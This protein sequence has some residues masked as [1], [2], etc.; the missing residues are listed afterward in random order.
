MIQGAEHDLQHGREV[1]FAGE[2]PVLLGEPEAVGDGGAAGFEVLLEQRGPDG[3]VVLGL[4]DQGSQV[5]AEVV[6]GEQRDHAGEEGAH[7]GQDVAGVGDGDLGRDALE[8]VEH[9]CALRWPPA[10]DGLLAHA[11]PGRDRLDGDRTT[12]TH[13]HMVVRVERTLPVPP[14]RAYRAWLE[15]GL[16]RRWM[17][18][19]RQEVTRVEIDERAGGAWRTWKAD[20]GVIVGGFD[21][22]LLELVPDRRLV[23]RWGFIGPQRR[24]G[25]S[26]DTLL[27]VSFDPGPA[28]GTVVRLVHERLGELAA[29]MPDIAAS[30]GPGWE[31]V[32]HLSASRVYSPVR[33]SSNTHKGSAQATS[34]LLARPS[35]KPRSP[36]LRCKAR[37][38]LKARCLARL[39]GPFASQ[40]RRR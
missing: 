33:N 21:S 18:P 15:P 8:G 13:D 32:C 2:L 1:E 16:V 37:S 27:T 29:A 20:D 38:I 25:P 6:V 26:F 3:G 24:Q 4:P 30:V 36:D 39:G 10:V 12:Q 23:F 34:W 5:G 11:G 17:A 35:P 19:G 28:G 40:S 14:H 7:V 31:A 22:E 9:Y